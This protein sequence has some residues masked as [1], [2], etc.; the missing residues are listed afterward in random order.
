MA[1]QLLTHNLTRF[2]HLGIFFTDGQTDV[3]SVLLQRQCTCI[4]GCV[5]TPQ[6]TTCPEAPGKGTCHA[7]DCPESLPGAETSQRKANANHASK[8]RSP[9][10][11]TVRR[12]VKKGNHRLTR[13]VKG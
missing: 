9:A 1:K 7:A 12:E 13:Y 3:T 5:Y 8:P 2:G 4:D 10:L 6:Q 11:E